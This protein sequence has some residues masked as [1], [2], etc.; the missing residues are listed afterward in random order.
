MRAIGR[1]RGEQGGL[2]NDSDAD[3]GD[4][5]PFDCGTTIWLDYNKRHT[6]PDRRSRRPL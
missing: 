4:L 2:I 1:P 3:H 5:V 6:P